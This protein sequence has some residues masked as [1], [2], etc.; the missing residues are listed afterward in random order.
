MYY[1]GLKFISAKLVHPRKDLYEIRFVDDNEVFTHTTPYG[2]LKKLNIYSLHSRSKDGYDQ[3]AIC[4]NSDKSR[5]YFMENFSTKSSV[6]TFLSS[7]YYELEQYDAYCKLR[8]LYWSIDYPLSDVLKV[9]QSF[10]DTILYDLYT[11]F[12]KSKPIGNTQ[13]RIASLLSTFKFN[14]LKYDHQLKQYK[15]V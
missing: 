6:N 7:H 4:F 9:V 15:K 11:Q 14:K 1:D 3:I 5:P 2:F 13:E 10:G 12:C 8:A